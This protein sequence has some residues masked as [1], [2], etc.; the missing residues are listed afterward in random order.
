MIHLIV[1]MTKDRVIGNNNK[2]LWQISD[3]MKL[4]KEL[5]T[6]NTVIMGRN[7]WESIPKKFRPLPNRKNIVVSKTLNRTNGAEIA[8]SIDDAVRMARGN[9]GQIYCIGGAQ[10]YK[11]FLEKELVDIL[12]ISFVK[13]EYDGN[14]FF[15]KI[16]FNEWEETETKE[17]NEFI[18][19]KFEKKS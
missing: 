11:E 18:Y 4:F 14:V 15:P 12:H 1:A 8:S 3:D 16:N 5:T 2:L 19:K 17:F 9:V 6:N 13:K 7:T 10:I